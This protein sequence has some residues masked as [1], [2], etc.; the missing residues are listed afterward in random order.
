[1]HFIIVM[2]RWTGLAP[3]EHLQ[4]FPG[5]LLPLVPNLSGLIDPPGDSSEHSLSVAVFL[6][7]KL[8]EM[9]WNSL[10]GGA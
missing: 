1:M 4:G 5:L 2:I 6:S 9:V 7:A 8:S 10:T 3:W